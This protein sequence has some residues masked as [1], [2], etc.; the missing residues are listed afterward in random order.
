MVLP[1]GDSR[2]VPSD[3]AK[4]QCGGRGAAPPCEIRRS[5][6]CY[7]VQFT[8]WRS[9]V[10]RRPPP[11]PPCKTSPAHPRAGQVADHQPGTRRRRRRRARRRHRRR[12][13]RR[14]TARRF[15]WRMNTHSDDLDQLFKTSWVARVA[16]AC[17]QCARHKLLL[18]PLECRKKFW[19]MCV[20][21]QTKSGGLTAVPFRC[22][23]ADVCS[24]SPS[25]S[26]RR[27]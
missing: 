14:L 22:G 1:A 16:S 4:V 10:H 6:R 23:D 8:G 24:T 21:C 26:Y 18:P 9:T 13:I 11:P 15:K 20:G 7:S 5:F 27:S 19:I 25:L 17:R 3:S 12:R 2:L